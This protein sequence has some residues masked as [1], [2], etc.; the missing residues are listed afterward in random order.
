MPGAL[1][2]LR[3]SAPRFAAGGLLNS[4]TAAVPQHQTRFITTNLRLPDNF[5]E[6]WPYKEK[7]YLLRRISPLHLLL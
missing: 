6:P 3:S 5:P 4:S 7:G 1:S 2:L